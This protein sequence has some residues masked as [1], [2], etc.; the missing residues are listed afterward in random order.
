MFEQLLELVKSQSGEAIVNNPAVPNEH[1]E[2]VMN[3]ATNSITSTLQGLLSSGGSNG[4]AQV[5]NMFSN[6]NAG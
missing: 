1:N 2:A 6:Q 3:E 4:I 5:L